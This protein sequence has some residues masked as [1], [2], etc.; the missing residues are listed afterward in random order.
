MITEAYHNC[1]FTEIVTLC[2][3]CIYEFMFFSQDKFNSDVMCTPT[4]IP[5]KSMQE[6][7]FVPCNSWNSPGIINLLV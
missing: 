6:F 2:N 7:Y 5:R 1:N 4:G 3:K